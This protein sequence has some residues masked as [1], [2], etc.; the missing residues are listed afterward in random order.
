MSQ[1]AALLQADPRVTAL[2]GQIRAQQ[3]AARR[4]GMVVPPDYIDDLARSVLR[5]FGVLSIGDLRPTVRL[6]Q[7]EPET[8]QSSGTWGNVLAYD[9][10]GAPW[11]EVISEDGTVYS[12]L[13]GN[14]GLYERDGM[15]LFD[16]SSDGQ[17]VY[18][19][20][21]VDQPGV[22][23]L[24]AVPKREPGNVFALTRQA[25][26]DLAPLIG[27]AVSMGGLGSILNTALFSPATIAAYPNATSAFSNA[28]IRTALSG[29]DVVGAARSAAASMAGAEFGNVVGSG[30]D[31]AQ[32]G[33]IAAAA[34]Q[35]ALQ[36]GN[37][38]A[39]VARS[40][41]TLGAQSVDDYINF[42][43]GDFTDPVPAIDFTQ[44]QD[45]GQD[46][47][48]DLAPVTLDDIGVTL[49]PVEI[50]D[51]LAINSDVFDSVDI[52][53][54]SLFPDEYGNLFLASGEYVELSDDIFAR[55][56]YVD[57]NGN[58]RAPDNN[59][60]IP[61]DDALNLTADQ[62]SA[63]IQRMM[64]ENAGTVT[65][66]APAPS[67]RPASIPPAASQTKWPTVADTARLLDTIG[68]LSVQLRST[69]QAVQGGAYRPPGPTSTTGTPRNTPVGVPV[70]LPD[71]RVV[72]NNG[73]GTQT[74]T[75]PDGRSVTV[76]SS[77]S[78]ASGGG[79][80]L[81][82]VSNQALFIGGAVLVGAVLLARRR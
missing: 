15:L 29:G 47:G 46:W 30:L 12:F 19:L 79:S 32:V 38:D 25:L 77:Y 28:V 75:G 11:S 48:N 71:G 70:R 67:S 14:V 33:T 39:A 58:I 72:L 63:E 62:L 37:V 18:G 43:S 52:D 24:F 7:V 68:R 78:G 27:M 2:A 41:L 65:Q 64:D 69:V 22:V 73:N 59:V 54:S 8:E 51:T 44:V 60:L 74:V 50:G 10:P 49:N 20:R 61:S 42:P 23:V 4:L 17:W 13:P 5:T 53:P 9:K 80:L 6:V 21:W 34:A 56:L 35:A 81:P 66:T 55:S 1:V 40:L 45:W 3:V 16:V 26:R 82:G 57:E 36:R 31:S 76:P